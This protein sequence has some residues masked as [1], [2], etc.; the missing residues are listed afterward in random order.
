MLPSV[1]KYCP[2]SHAVQTVEPEV[3]VVPFAQLIHV[4]FFPC[5]TLYVSAA[6]LIHLLSSLLPVFVVEYLPGEQSLQ[7]ALLETPSADEYFPA[8]QSLHESIDVVL[9]SVEYFPAMQLLQPA[10]VSSF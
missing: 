4:V 8:G 3:D 10:F 6:Q 9:T 5:S 7:P 2:A 1:S